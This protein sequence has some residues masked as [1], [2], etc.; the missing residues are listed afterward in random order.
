MYYINYEE[1]HL[2]T[3]MQ[4]I[5]PESIQKNIKLAIKDIGLKEVIHIIGLEEVIKAVG[6]E[7]V[8]KTLHKLK[9]A[10]TK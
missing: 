4:S 7:E 2:M 3:D 5:L 6:L 8:E 9:A 10:Q 1:V